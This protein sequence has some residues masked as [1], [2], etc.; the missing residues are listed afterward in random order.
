M[1]LTGYSHSWTFMSVLLLLVQLL[2][3]IQVVLQTGILMISEKLKADDAD[4]DELKPGK[5]VNKKWT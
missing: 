2:R 1:G 5:Q 3:L 4:L